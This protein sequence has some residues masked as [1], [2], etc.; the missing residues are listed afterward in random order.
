MLSPGDADDAVWEIM[1]ELVSKLSIHVKIINDKIWIKF[2]FETRAMTVTHLKF[3]CLCLQH[4]S[5][6]GLWA[7]KYLTDTLKCQIMCLDKGDG[8]GETS[9]TE[10]SEPLPATLDPW[11]QGCLPV[12]NFTHEFPCMSPQVILHIF[13][14]TAF[15]LLDWL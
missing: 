8:A 15:C 9:R 3:L 7:K 12:V 6:S 1:D 2:T 14:V 10:D 4:L 13:H 11:A 5:Y